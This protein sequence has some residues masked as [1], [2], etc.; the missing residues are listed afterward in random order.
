MSHTQKTENYNLPQ[1]LEN[2]VPAWLTDFNQSMVLIDS[3]IK[4]VS[5]SGSG[6]VVDVTSL[7]NDV[8]T[9]KSDVVEI[10]NQISGLSSRVG[11]TEQDINDIKGRMSIVE[12]EITSIKTALGNT[13]T[14]VGKNKT[15]IE[16][17]SET[18]NDVNNELIRATTDNFVE[19]LA[20]GWSATAPYE[21]TLLLDGMR[22]SINPVYD[23]SIDSELAVDVQNA[24]LE[25]FS[26]VSHL[27]TF[28]GSIKL[29]CNENKPES[30]F[31]II[32]K[33]E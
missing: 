33:G 25:S 31:T 24:M 16:G 20:T 9:L 26:C 8:A 29:I 32:V 3:A 19:V 28:N 12:G 5:D 15:A 13:N 22:D 4:A 7:K 2:D 10:E 18:I 17:L 6:V 21:C 14:E 1:F 23:V 11:I 27:I 30:N